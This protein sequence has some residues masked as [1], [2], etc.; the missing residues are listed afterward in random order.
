[1]STS[2]P[3]KLTVLDKVVE[4]PTKLD[5]KEPEDVDKNK[6]FEKKVNDKVKRREEAAKLAEAK[7]GE[8]VSFAK[9]AAKAKSHVKDKTEMQNFKKK[10]PH[11]GD[12]E[13]L[14]RCGS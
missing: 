3:A 12:T 8:E 5:E 10:I 7:A 1:M 14:D 11:T 4:E 9:V 13:S 2:S 6:V